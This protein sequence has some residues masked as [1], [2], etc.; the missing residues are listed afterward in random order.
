MNESE[1]FG[2]LIWRVGRMRDLQKTDP[3]K[4]RPWQAADLLKLEREVD[5]I[6][7]KYFAEEM[8]PAPPSTTGGQK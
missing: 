7:A 1:V 3:D 2:H 4:L 8:M 6:V 5:E